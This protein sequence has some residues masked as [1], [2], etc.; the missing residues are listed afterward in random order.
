MPSWRT[1]ERAKLLL[2]AAF[3]APFNLPSVAPGF[4]AINRAASCRSQG[5]CERASI[6]LE[7]SA[8]ATVPSLM[9]AQAGGAGFHGQYSNCTLK[10]G[11]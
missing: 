8:A 5:T 1:P 2:A 7:M 10:A 3:A 9:P 6:D 4:A 11:K